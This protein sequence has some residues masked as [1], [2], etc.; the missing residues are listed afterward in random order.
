MPY[1]HK[2]VKLTDQERKEVESALKELLHRRESKKRRRLQIIYW[3]DQ[4]SS[5]DSIA[6]SLYFSYATVRRWIYRWQKEGIKPFL[7]RKK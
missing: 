5:Y 2:F 6:K 7:P 1:P 3:S 4:G